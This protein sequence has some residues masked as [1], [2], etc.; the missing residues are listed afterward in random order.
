MNRRTVLTELGADR[1]ALR[2]EDRGSILF[3]LGLGA[4]QADFCVRIDDPDIDR[5]IAPTCRPPV[6]EPAIP[7]WD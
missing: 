6:F 2:P 7:R 5:A 3:D 1:D 4:L